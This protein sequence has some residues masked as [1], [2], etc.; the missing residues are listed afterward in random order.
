VVLDHG[1]LASAMRAS[2]AVPGMFSPVEIDGRRLVD[3]GAAANLPI[4][5]AQSLGAEAVIA[6]DITSPL[7]TSEELQSFFSVMSQWSS[8]ATVANRLEDIKRLRPGDVLITPE[9]G[10]ISFLDFTRTVEAIGI[11]E[12]TARASVESLR[13]FAVTDAEWEEFARRHRTPRG[14]QVIVD[15]V[16]FT[17]NS[18][19]DDRVIERRLKIPEGQPFDQKSFEDTVMRLYGLDY[20]GLIRPS[21]ERNDGGGTLS[22]DIP[23]K[24]YGKN[25]L[26]FGAS[27]QDDFS[28]G[29]NYTFALRHLKLAVNRRG[30]EWE[31]VGQIGQKRLL[32]TSFYQ[33][34]DYG[35]HWFV[36]PT[37]RIERENIYLWEEGERIAEVGVETNYG[38]LDAGAV[39]GD[40]GE[41]RLG[42]YFAHS[43][44]KPIIGDTTLGADEEHDGGV[45]FGFR[46]DTRD[47]TVFPRQ[48]VQVNGWYRDS[49]ESL[50]ADADRQVARLDADIALTFG[51]VTFVP[52]FSG[53]TL[54]TGP[55]SFLSACALGG[56][57]N[58]S[59]LG[60][61]EL[62]G[63][64]C[65]LGRGISYVRLTHLD[66]GPLSTAMYGG[67]S[68]EAGNVYFRG[69]PVTWDSLTMGGSLFVGA[70]TPIGPAFVA[71]GTT[72]HG[73]HRLY[74]VIG[75]RF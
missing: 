7:Y 66:L 2:M 75:D 8:F 60:V 55:V 29:A 22:L 18:W 30:G 59:G 65:V 64:R 25:S 12:Q 47:S 9:L 17:N 56:F 35:M 4:G 14:D 15:T 1:S 40:W 61:G 26:Q 5:I 23:K 36:S 21:Y 6:V 19:V 70:Q 74:F 57:L 32:G 24:P 52:S 42:A 13:R 43:H 62:L 31:N 63:E 20:F 68:L 16:R 45:R 49:S 50:G 3:G 54:V 33:P 10:D 41:V 38:V 37:A 51:R 11:G 72:E 27:F 71:W 34:L 67:L 69:D 53:Q 48:G 73:E 58:L 46:A 28:G 39:L 44:A